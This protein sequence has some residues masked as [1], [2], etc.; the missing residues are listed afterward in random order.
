MAG[1]VKRGGSVTVSA[2]GGYGKPCPAVIVHFDVLDAADS[3][4]VALFT[5]AISDAPL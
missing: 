3:V 5:C 4:L 2:P 1:T